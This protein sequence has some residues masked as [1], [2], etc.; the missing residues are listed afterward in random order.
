MLLWLVLFNASLSHLLITAQ[1]TEIS[2]SVKEQRSLLC[3]LHTEC[4]TPVQLGLD[5][6]P[7]WTFKCIIL[8]SEVLD[9]FYQAK[10]Q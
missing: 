2:V 3:A 1:S 8:L 9:W 5:P 4:L 10:Y 7:T 6:L